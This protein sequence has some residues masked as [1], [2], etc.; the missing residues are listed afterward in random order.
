MV[1]ITNGREVYTVTRG[2]FNEV[3][4]NQGFFETLD[5]RS[6]KP[7]ETSLDLPDSLPEQVTTSAAAIVFD[8]K[9]DE[10][11]I[12]VKSQSKIENENQVNPEER[13][14]SEIPISEMTDK[15]LKEYAAQLGVDISGLTSRKAV[16]NKIKSAL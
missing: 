8:E 7:L 6:S 1:T 10:S 5:N 11:G 4:K 13:D 14:L 2:A 16:R 15:Q 12:N 9:T 3:F